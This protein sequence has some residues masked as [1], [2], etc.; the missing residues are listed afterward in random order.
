ME[1]SGRIAIVTGAASGLGLA[2]ALRFAREGAV[3][4]AADRNE[5]EGIALSKRFD[6]IG[7]EGIFVKTDISDESSVK[8]LFELALRSLQADRYF[9]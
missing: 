8:N 2:V 7:R 6:E 3:V 1:L 4:I 9:V 5:A